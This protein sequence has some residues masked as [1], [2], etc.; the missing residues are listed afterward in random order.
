MSKV[1]S[2]REQGEPILVVLGNHR[3]SKVISKKWNRDLPTEDLE[4]IQYFINGL[5]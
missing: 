3:I 5:E 1:S 4:F 2:I